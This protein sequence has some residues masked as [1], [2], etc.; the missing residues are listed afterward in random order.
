LWIRGQRFHAEW[1]SGGAS[2]CAV[3][4]LIVNDAPSGRGG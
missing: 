2:I 1:I 4:C 3:G